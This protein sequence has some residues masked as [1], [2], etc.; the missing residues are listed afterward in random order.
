MKAVSRSSFLLKGG[1][2]FLFY[3]DLQLIVRGSSTLRRVICST[4]LTDS[5][6][7]STR[8]PLLE[9]PRMVFDQMSGYPMAQSTHMKLII[10][11]QLG[12][13]THLLN[14]PSSADKDNIKVLISPNMSQ[15]F[16]TQWKLH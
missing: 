16:Y 15:L 3:S 10:T 6:I 14:H 13:H 11:R 12:I 9:T 7:I 1:S 4:Q 8:S 2:A 5:N